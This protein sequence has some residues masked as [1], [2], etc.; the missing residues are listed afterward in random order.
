MIVRSIRAPSCVVLID[1]AATEVSAPLVIFAPSAVSSALLHSR[2]GAT[3][4]VSIAAVNSTVDGAGILASPAR[5]SGRIIAAGR[6][7]ADSSLTRPTA[8]SSAGPG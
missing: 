2:T 8:M 6:D 3:A 1:F 7:S 4:C 5:W